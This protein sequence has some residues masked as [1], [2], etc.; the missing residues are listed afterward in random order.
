MKF[1][2]DGM[3][4][5]AEHHYRLVLDQQYRVHDVLPLI[6]GIAKERG[7]FDVALAYWDEL[8]RLMPDH[9]A[10]YLEKGAIMIT[11]GDV[12]GAIGCFEA[13]LSVSPH[14]S[15]AL[16]NLAVAFVQAGRDADALRTYQKLLGVR[17]DH[18]H[19]RHQV[20]RLSSRIV[21]FWHIPMLN[22]VKRNDAFEAAIARAIAKQGTSAPIL[23]IG[24]GSGLLS[25]MAARAGAEN[26]VTCEA[27]PVIA[28]A[29]NA[30]IA[31]NA[32]S[33]RI[34]VVNKKSTEMVIGKDMATRASILISEI[35][36]SDLLAEDVLDTFEDAHDRLITEDAIIIPRAATAIGCL[37]ESD[38][39][40]K[41]AFVQEVS[42]FDVSTFSALAANRLPIHGTMTEWKR[43][44]PDVELQ[45]IDL[46]H[47]NYAEELF[48][49]E[50]PVTT[51]GTAIGIVQW[52]HIDLAEGIEFTNHPDSYCDGGWLQILHPF[53]E[54]VRVKAGSKFRIIAG[55]D[56]SS[57]ILYPAPFKDASD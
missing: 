29:A 3:L 14:H 53:P 18:I 39:L 49:V 8:L 41:Y 16:N 42:G 9:I 17:P 19:A 44:S 4:E 2:S 45:R 57:L 10:A 35:L 55:H 11:N 31:Q 40:A 5:D 24:A 52:I 32:F 51:E 37:V 1:H 47:K 15:L 33:D 13:A 27:V 28:D 6:A 25:M 38:V 56:R 22:D 50:F 23:D 30:I 12:G 7:R 21:P 43:L 26:I 36:S 54:P 20:R 46:T 34:S 48:Y